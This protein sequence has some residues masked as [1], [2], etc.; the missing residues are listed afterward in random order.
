MTASPKKLDEAQRSKSMGQPNPCRLKSKYFILNII[1]ALL[2]VP[3][4]IFFPRMWSTLDDR[5]IYHRD[6]HYPECYID[7]QLRFRWTTQITS[8][9]AWLEHL[10]Y[11]HGDLT[12]GNILL[13]WY[14]NIK[15]SDF[16][17]CVRVGEE[18][19][20]GAPPYVPW[21]FET[22]DHRS[23]QY[24]IGWTIYSLYNNIPGNFESPEDI[25]SFQ[26]ALFPDTSN[27]VV[28]TIIC[29]CWRL[30]YQS[31]GAL[32]LDMQEELQC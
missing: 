24:A 23:E 19:Q 11:A 30:Q 1:Q 13:D 29:K 8:A 4:G 9:A 20:C 18:S 3:E 5:V 10:G 16:G 22:R 2:I 14:D 15:L 28:G 31:I 27:I 21:V 25:N 17:E 7:N 12:P 6:L 32:S 26:T